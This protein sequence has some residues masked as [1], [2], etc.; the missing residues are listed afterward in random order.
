MPR[1]RSLAA[2]LVPALLALAL[3]LLSGDP[4]STPTRAS[5]RPLDRSDPSAPSLA[6]GAPGAGPR[7]EDPGTTPDAAAGKPPAAP[8]E[9]TVRVT[10]EFDRPIAEASLFV[11]D[12]TRP[13]PGAPAAHTDAEGAARLTLDAHP[14]VRLAAVARGFR[15]RIEPL[16]RVDAELGGTLVL[17]R[18]AA[19]AGR[20]VGVDGRGLAGAR[21]WCTAR[22]G[23]SAWPGRGPF[24]A[25]HSALGAEAIS[26]AEGR[27]VLEGLDPGREV[28]LRASRPGL[29][30]EHGPWPTAT[31]GA[32]AG[33]VRIVLAPFGRLDVRVVDAED[34][35]PIDG[36]R[37]GVRYSEAIGPAPAPLERPAIRIHDGLV[38]AIDFAGRPGMGPGD[39]GEVLLHL[40]A[41]GY[42]KKS[43]RVAVR[44]AEEQATQIALVRE[45]G[46]GLR[47]LRFG[48]GFAGGAPYDGVL[49]VHLGRFAVPVEFE[50]G[51][52]RRPVRMPCGTWRLQASG[53]GHQGR[54]WGEASAAVPLVVAAGPGEQSVALALRGACLQIHARAR[55]GAPVRDFA[56]GFVSPGAPLMLESDWTL[57]AR[58]AAERPGY[59][60]EDALEIW[61]PPGP[62][63]LV[64]R[65]PVL[66][67]GEAELVVPA[68]GALL[69]LTLT[70]DPARL[71]PPLDP[72]LLAP[73]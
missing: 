73:R 46:A 17:A 64:A 40:E 25:P 7:R 37:L 38:T 16:A 49:A 54:F 22:G 1:L 32:G 60:W 50:R 27:F 8:A 52:A 12:P 19:L 29:W 14:Q 43:E 44:L 18:G 33:E 68:D 2:V 10:D 36:L 61:L 24:T 55:D 42:E 62:I 21:V 39:A 56:L 65:D 4:A 3:W 15:T 47:A 66:G 58:A 45:E 53:W 6:G 69:P 72:A 67:Q 57:R 48:A 9:V 13:P 70:L 5:L 31:P 30:R 23:E 41:P 26:D 11:L 63:K 28:R 71:P 20:V 35:E 51:R 59:G 34:G